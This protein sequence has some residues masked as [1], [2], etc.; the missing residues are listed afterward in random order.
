MRNLPTN[1]ILI[2]GEFLTMI[3]DTCD[4]FAVNF[5]ADFSSA[6]IKCCKFNQPLSW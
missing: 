4:V 2:Y 3:E 5:A 1:R 6:D